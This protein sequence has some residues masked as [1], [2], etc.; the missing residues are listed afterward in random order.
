MTQAG[1]GCS[2]RD[3]RIVRST[4]VHEAHRLVMLPTQRTL[5]G[6]ARPS[7][8][9]WDN[10]RARW[11]SVPSLARAPARECADSRSTTLATI[12]LTRSASAALV[13]WAGNST[14][15]RSPLR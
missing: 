7:R 15:I 9:A 8:Y 11:A 4:M 6:R 1:I 3:S 13:T 14:T 2:R 10:S 5:A 12:S